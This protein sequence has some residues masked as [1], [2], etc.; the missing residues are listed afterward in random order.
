[1]KHRKDE[2]QVNFTVFY[3]CSSIG[4]Y[5]FK[6]L[7]IISYMKHIHVSEALKRHKLRSSPIDKEDLAIRL[8]EP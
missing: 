4:N 8:R 3:L 2:K 1:M 7:W 5:R 6:S